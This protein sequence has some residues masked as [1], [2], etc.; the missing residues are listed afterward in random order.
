MDERANH[1]GSEPAQTPVRP[2]PLIG[3]MVLGFAASLVI[4]GIT[5]ITLYTSY[6]DSDTAQDVIPIA[7]LVALPVL[8]ALL[9]IPK[10]TR[11]WGAGF[12][13]GVAI[14]AITGAGTCGSI[15]LGGR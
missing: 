14:G 12:L 13:L 9:M 5:L 3:G 1:P 6:G 11:L 4:F 7:A 8:C 2:W 15:L 10:R